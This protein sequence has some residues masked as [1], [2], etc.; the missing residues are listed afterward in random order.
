M[1]HDLSRR[2]VL[3]IGV[4]GA[5]LPVAQYAQALA[6][7]RRGFRFAYFSDTHVMLNR[8]IA[9]NR[10]MLAELRPLRPVLA[11]NGGDITENGW[12]GQY[13]NYRDLVKDLGFP[14]Y[15]VPGNHDVR[16]SPLGMQVY[17]RH[18][19]PP[20]RRVDHE[21]VAFLL[22]DSTV[23]LS[24]WGH[25]ESLQLRW[26]RAELERIGPD[27]PAILAMHHWVG[28]ERVMVAN[29]ASLLALLAKHNVPLLLTGHGHSDLIW[30]WGGATG[31]MNRGLY[32]DSYMI[33]DV[34]REDG[35]IRVAR[36]TRERPQLEPLT[37]VPLRRKRLVAPRW[38]PPERLEY[39]AP[40]VLAGAAGA[41]FRWNAARW[42]P[43]PDGPIPTAGLRP[44]KHQLTLRQGDRGPA[45][46]F[47]VEIED[48]DAPLR[49]AWMTELGAGVMSH[50]RIAR[51]MLLVSCMDGS[52]RALG[53]SSG[54]PVWRAQT[55][56]YCHSS[57]LAGGERVFVGSADG[58]VYAFGL[59]DGRRLWKTRTGG[60]VYASAAFAQGIVTIAS[61]DGKF[62]GL[63]PATGAVRWTYEM[64]ESNTAFAQSVA[65][66]DGERV[67]IG[68]WDSHLYAIEAATG[69]FLWRQACM[70]RTFAFSPAIGGPAVAG[71]V[72]IVPA[73]GNGLF[74]F[75]TA[76][77]EKRWE[78]AAEG[79]KFGHSSPRIV[80]DRIYVG[81]LGD[82][83]QVRCMGMDG[84]ELWVAE[85]GSEIYDSSPAVADG[86][87]SIGSVDGTLSLI[88]ATNGQIVHQHRLNQGHFLSSPAAMPGW[89]F[90]ASFGDRAYGF[91]LAR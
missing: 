36:R 59:R 11:V 72:V 39:G 18:L 8:N 66:T 83:G 29:E 76:T 47:E 58:H 7:P 71:G 12:E 34:D 46:A 62:Y 22:L 28:R 54:R 21:G 70:P 75:D 41:Q 10:A 88:E 5:L 19:G 17:E 37:E 61:G 35:V 73:N 48:P 32:Q 20:F 16:W 13:A 68:A 87:V 44:G 64:P 80:G 9:E 51:G 2:D 42:T 91:R 31:L 1:A 67:F 14:V 79:D 4:A 3:K 60:P 55:G 43:A 25:F 81:C 24:H 84:Q 78:V 6:P 69:R 40:L 50:L 90:A 89:V 56:A 15:D 33:L 63:D 26:L 30:E 74:C 57:P 86:L 77:G 23:P 38:S 85:T 82:K 27:D 53:R 45:A 65:A 52:V 49:V